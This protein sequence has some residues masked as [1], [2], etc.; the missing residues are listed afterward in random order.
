MTT[1]DLRD[2]N[3][4]RKYYFLEDYLFNEVHRRFH[5]QGYLAA[6]DFFCIVIW[7]SNR[8]KSKVAERLLLM[9][10]KESDLNKV[11]EALTAGLAKQ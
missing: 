3:E 4:Y 11:V 10:K 6:E 8:A 2:P 9:G 7:K 1:L 5:E